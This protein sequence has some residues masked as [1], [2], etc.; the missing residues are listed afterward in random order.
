M[1]AVRATILAVGSELLS[2]ERLDTN[3]LRLTAL[4]ER[5]GVELVKKSVVGDLEAEISRELAALWEASDLLLVSGGLGPTGDDLTREAAAAALGVTLVSRPDVLAQI[6]RRFAAMGR[7]LS[8]NNRKQAEVLV[9]AE[10]LDNPN[11]SAPG[12]LF[13]RAGK[14]LFLFPGVP[15]ELDGMAAAFLVPWLERRSGG[16]TRETWTIKVAMRPESELDQ[17][18]APAYAEFG[19]EWM[20]VLAGAGEVRVLLT[21][22][23][24]ERER[25]E[26]LATMRQRTLSLL[27][28]GVF[29]EGA[30]TTL[31]SVVARLLTEGGWTLGTAESCT[32]GLVAE[33]MT[34]VPGVSAVFVGGVVTYSNE[35]K[36]ALLGVPPDLLRRV[37]A[38]SEEVAREM[39][40]GVCRR[41]GS[42]IGVGIT[43][44]AGPGGGSAE[45]PVGTVHV[46]VAGPGATPVEHRVARFPG[47]RERI[48][49]FAAQMALELLRRRLVA[50]LATEAPGAPGGRA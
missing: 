9:G 23:G 35:S 28:D 27:G 30:E 17:A 41:L 11:G 47:S 25:R 18:L 22:V 5:F 16:A 48:R 39:A 12:Q 33:R 50:A 44:I 31:E 6:E 13:E 32:G 7:R 15:F 10:V 3:S 19:Q 21:A 37:G 1:P 49:M 4:L 24:G 42:A 34:R 2:T 14:A 29:G 46:A 8:P 38:V 20:T 26:R 43:G 45:K 40:T 36:S